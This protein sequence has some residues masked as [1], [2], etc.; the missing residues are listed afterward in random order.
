M[1]DNKVG[2]VLEG[3]G[4][5]GL[6]TAG[7]LDMFLDEKIHFPY[8]IGVS[9]GACNATSYISKQRGRNKRVTLDYI[10]DKRYISY[11]N[12]FKQGSM[13]GMDF[14]FNDIPNKLVNF[15]YETFNNSK[16]KFVT[17]ATDCETGKSVYFEKNE[18]EDINRVLRAS[19]SLPFI[20]NIVDIKGRKF[21]D[22]GISDSIPVKK[23]LEDGY[24]KLVIVLTRN[25]EY[26]KEPFKFKILLKLL[27]KKYPN[28]VKKILERHAN[29]NNTLKYIEKLE[30]EGKAFI[31]RPKNS[32][33][34]SRT[35]RNRN[36]LEKIYNIGY[37]EAVDSKKRLLNFI[38]H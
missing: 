34:V 14:I 35:E 13:F 33:N 9:M 11:S 32:L 3:G 37:Q 27:Y 23:A 20:S 16:Q 28:I 15:D 25:K 17:I 2:L 1:L 24:E 31:I 22:G 10:N 8:V 4:L 18:C 12:L 29:Y 6:Y 38:A 36:K 7:V 26:I 21:L 5:R 30:K 19:S